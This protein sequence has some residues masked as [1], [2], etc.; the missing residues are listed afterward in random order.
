VNATLVN[1]IKDILNQHWFGTAVAIAGIVIGLV[2]AYSSRSRSRLAAQTNTLELA[3]SNAVLPNEIEF[4]FRGNRVP[5]VTMS[6]IAIWNIGNTT[7]KGDQIVNSD[8][9]RIVTSDGSSVLEATIRNRTRQVNDVSCLLRQGTSNEVECRF[10]YL[11][12]SDGALIQL[13]HTGSNEIKVSGTLRG[14]PKGVLMRSV[15]QQK[16]QVQ[17]QLSPSALRLIALVFIV[18]GI[19]FFIPAVS[20]KVRPPSDSTLVVMLSFA[21]VFIG[22]ILLLSSRSLPP[23]QLSTEITSNERKKSSWQIWTGGK[24]ILRVKIR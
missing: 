12:P 17:R 6:R 5:N 18:L 8:P 16:V 19:C 1:E 22:L 4:L 9:L 11:D 7:I 13:I 20:G 23:S 15:P 21:S 2:I 24:G 14:I 3:G 10:D